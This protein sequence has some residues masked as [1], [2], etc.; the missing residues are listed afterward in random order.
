MLC[1]SVGM[2]PKPNNGTLRLPLKPIGLHDAEPAIEELED[3]ETTTSSPATVASAVTAVSASSTEQVTTTTTTTD[4]AQNPASTPPVGV[5]LVAPSLSKPL[6][7]DP[8]E[9]GPPE[10]PHP[11]EDKEDTHH[12]KSI[13]E[14]WDWLKD[15]AGH[16]WDKVKGGSESS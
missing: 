9:T 4:A 13:T 16:V 8:V 6:G 5:D 12:F 11:N 10:R 2:E 14:L 3:P 7:V 1:D 15:K